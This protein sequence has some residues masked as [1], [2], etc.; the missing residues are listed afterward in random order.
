MP[1]GTVWSRLHSARRNARGCH[2][3]AR[4]AGGYDR[5]IQQGGTHREKIIVAAGALLFAGL[6][7]V[8]EDSTVTFI[9]HEQVAKGGSLVT[10]PNLSITVAHRTEPGMVEVHDKETDTFYVL[11]GSATIVT[12]GKMP[13]R[14][15]DGSRA[16]T[17]HRHRGRPSPAS[18][19]RRRHGDPG[20]RGALVQNSPEL[21]RLLRRQSHRAVAA[22][23]NLRKEK[24]DRLRGP[25]FVRAAD[26]RVRRARS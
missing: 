3:R 6:L 15:R 17:R 18:S 23:Q 12:G 4:T 22:L 13:R 10:A 20:R 26:V 14:Q 19:G 8:A 5:A 21:D 2:E 11:A 1:V 16:T 9:G 24:G 7:G 25:L